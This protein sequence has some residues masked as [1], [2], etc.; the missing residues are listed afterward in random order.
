MNLISTTLSLQMALLAIA[1]AAP[2]PVQCAETA[3]VSQHNLQAKIIYCKTCHGLAA[4]GYR[5]AGAGPMPRL[6]GQQREYFENQLEA[7]VDGRRKN[8]FMF[9]VAKVLSPAM[10]TA[11][12]AHFEKLNPKPIGG[13]PRWLVRAGKKFYEEGVPESEI[14]PCSSCHGADAKGGTDGPRLA[15]QLRDYTF[16]TLMHWSNERAQDPAKPDASA[17]I[18]EPIARSLT[19]KQV[20]A[21][22]AYLS[23]LE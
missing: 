21:V 3:T 12:A 11:L 23:E 10:R 8:K 6:A 17:A 19:E 18:M 15:G 22:A 5:G 16:K 14:A 9:D 2:G 1:L 13:T 7:F 20:S 4:E